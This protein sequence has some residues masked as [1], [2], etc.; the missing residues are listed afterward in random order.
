MRSNNE[1]TQQSYK[2]LIVKS[3]RSKKTCTHIELRL[4]E[5]KHIHKYTTNRQ[6]PNEIYNIIVKRLQYNNKINMETLIY[7]CMNKKHY[8]PNSSTNDHNHNLDLYLNLY[9]R[10]MHYRYLHTHNPINHTSHGKT[11]DSDD[12]YHFGNE[13]YH[14]CQLAL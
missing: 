11:K 9:P 6:K 13:S 14:G 8:P 7:K 4:S 5:L 3:K 12:D 10:T 1:N 2:S